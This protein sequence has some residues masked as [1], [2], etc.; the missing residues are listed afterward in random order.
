MLIH[1]Q[2]TRSS[3]NRPLLGAHPFANQPS[4]IL[5]PHRLMA[6]SRPNATRSTQR[7]QR[8]PRPLATPSAELSKSNMWRQRRKPH[9]AKHPHLRKRSPRYAGRRRR[10]HPPTDI[11]QLQVSNHL[12]RPAQHTLRPG[13]RSPKDPYLITQLSAPHLPLP[14]VLLLVV[15]WVLRGCHLEG[16]HTGSLP[17][18][19]SPRRM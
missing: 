15:L 4:R 17:W 18:R 5:H 1:S 19:P 10:V 7:H 6:V 14:P 11:N 12:V 9:A 16:T 8:S 13:D 3:N 2:K